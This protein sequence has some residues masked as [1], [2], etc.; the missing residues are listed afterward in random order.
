MIELINTIATKSYVPPDP[1]KRVAADFIA[2]QAEVLDAI[3]APRM[4]ALQPNLLS[5]KPLTEIIA[6]STVIGSQFKFSSV[7]SLLEAIELD[8][9]GIDENDD[10]WELEGMVDEEFDHVPEEIRETLSDRQRVVFRRTV[11]A[12]LTLEIFFVL[13]VVY[14]EIPGM[15]HPSG[16]VGVLLT[17]F[18]DVR[19]VP[20]KLADWADEDPSD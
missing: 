14:G 2:R 4:K 7:K 12:L 18:V 5:T 1:M 8:E 9:I 11:R 13:L 17:M 16:W 20:K 15:P 3:A 6:N 10:P 19:Q